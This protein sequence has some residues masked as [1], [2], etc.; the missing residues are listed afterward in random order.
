[1]KRYTVQMDLSEPEALAVVK[2][3]HREIRDVESY[4]VKLD[5]NKAHLRTRFPERISAD[6]ER[7]TAKLNGLREIY[8]RLSRELVD[9]QI[10]N[11]PADNVAQ[12]YEL[13]DGSVYS[14]LHLRSD[15][16]NEIVSI[17]DRTGAKRKPEAGDFQFVEWS[18]RERMAD[19]GQA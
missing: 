4:L 16:V 11:M 14:L 18:I 6:R 3:L 5:Q 1:M 19:R 2:L 12:L 13:R 15:R 17:I 7:S 9:T 8:R 10:K